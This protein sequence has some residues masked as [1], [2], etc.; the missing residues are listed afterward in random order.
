MH[1]RPSCSSLPNSQLG[2]VLIVS[3][4]V[5]G[6]LTITILAPSP[7]CVA[8]KDIIVFMLDVNGF[9]VWGNSEC[10]N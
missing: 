8:C 3:S 5:F 10:L 6:S 7:L 1:S 4:V 2:C 9:E